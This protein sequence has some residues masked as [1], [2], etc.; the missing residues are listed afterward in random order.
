MAVV[1]LQRPS[2]LD[3]LLTAICD[4]VDQ[5]LAKVLPPVVR[6]GIE[7]RG[8][9]DAGLTFAAGTAVKVP[10]HLGR[11]PQRWWVTRDFGANANTLR[12]T[13]RDDKFLTLVSGVACTV[14]IWV[15]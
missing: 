1:R 10:H 9:K 14:Y 15:G 13:A 4:A 6:E 2:G 7:L 5:A 3:Q 8:D 11:V 12:E